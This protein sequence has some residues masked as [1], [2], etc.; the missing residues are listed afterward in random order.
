V[1]TLREQ[2]KSQK[3][4]NSGTVGG[5]VWGGRKGSDTEFLKLAWG[6]GVFEPKKKD[7]RDASI[8]QRADLKNRVEQYGNEKKLTYSLYS[9]KRK[10]SR[11]CV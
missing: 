2:S 11:R 9:P 6:L 3:A 1:G 10:R 4:A 8:G 7:Q 5:C